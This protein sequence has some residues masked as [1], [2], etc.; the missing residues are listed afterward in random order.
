M[1]VPSHWFA[2]LRHFALAFF[3]VCVSAPTLAAKTY[4]DNGDGTVTDPTTG[5][6]WM[7]CAMGQT[8]SMFNGVG[9]CS[10]PAS[11]FE[12]SSSANSL[13]RTMIFADRYDWRLPNIRELLS[14]VDL[15]VAM[16]ATDRL[17][18]PNMFD[19]G[20]YIIIPTYLSSSGHVNFEDGNTS[21]YSSPFRVRLV[22]GAQSVFFI[23]NAPPITDYK[24]NTDGTV[25]N[26]TTG[27]TW[28]RCP[29]GQKLFSDTCSGVALELTFY[30]A[31]T[32]LKNAYTM[33][34]CLKNDYAPCLKANIKNTSE[35]QELLSLVASNTDWRFPT[36]DELLSN[37]DYSKS[38][39]SINSKV[40]P[41]SS[42]PN[43]WSGTRYIDGNDLWV[44]SFCVGTSYRN[45]GAIKKN[46]IILVRGISTA[47]TSPTTVT[48]TISTTTTGLVTTT[49]Q[50][51]ATKTYTD[52]GGAYVT[53]PTTGLVWMRC[54]MGQIW[55]GVTCTGTAKTYTFPQAMAIEQGG[56]RLPNVRELLSIVDR[57][58]SNP[59][60]DSIVFPN[61]SHDRFLSLSFTAGSFLAWT[62]NFNNG[63]ASYNSQYSGNPY[64][65][66]AFPVRLVFGSSP[67]LKMTHPDNDYI[68]NKDG[69]V[70]D[71]ITGLMWQ[72][73]SIGS[74]TL[75]QAKKLIS[76]LGGYTDWRLPTVDELI[77]LLDYNVLDPTMKNKGP[78]INNRIFLDTS[79]SPFLSDSVY[80][81][82]PYGV[83]Y[84]D[85][86]TGSVGISS[87]DNASVVRLVRAGKSFI[88]FTLTVVKSGT[89]F[90]GSSAVGGILCGTVCTGS[91][92]PGT[93]I[94]LRAAPAANVTWGGACTG[95]MP[96]CT[97]NMDTA[98]SVTATFKDT[99]LV[100]GLPSD[101]TFSTQTIGS[102]SQAQTVA[103]KNTG[104]TALNITSIT[105]SGDFVV[106]NNCG[107]GIGAG[108]FC[109]LYVSYKPTV[110]GKQTGILTITDDAL[111]S[112]HTISLTGTG[113]GAVA[114]LALN[115][116]GTV[117]DPTTGLIWMRC[118]MGQ[119]WDGTT[120]T[121]TANTYRFGMANALKVT[122]AGQGDWRVPNI[123]ELQT[124]VDRSVVNP[125]INRAAF[126]NTSASGF[127]SASAYAGSSDGAW[128]VNFYDGGADYSDKS[129]A[130]QVRL[131]RA[132]QSF[133]LLNVSRPNSD[134]VDH[135]DGTVTHT[136]TGLMWQKCAMGQ[137]WR[138]DTCTGTA[139]TYKWD[140]ARLLT[141]NLAGQ[142]DWRL[143]TE[144][145][146][147]SLSDYSTT[148]PTINT[149]LFPDPNASYFWSASA[150]AGNSNYA[151]YVNFNDGYADNYGG[152]KSNAFQVRLVRAGQ[153]FDPFSLNIS[154]NGTGTVSSAFAGINCGTACSGSYTQGTQIIL[155]ATPAANFISWD[156]AC[157]GSATT[158]TVTMDAAKSVT[159]TFSGAPTTTT[160][161][162]PTTTTTAIPTTTTT[163]T[164]PP[165]TTTTLKPTTTTTTAIPTTTT[166]ALPTTTTTLRPTTTTSV[167]TTTTSSTVTTTTT[168]S[169][170]ITT[171]TTAIPTTTTTALPTTTTTLR[172]TTTTTTAIPTTTTTAP[173]TTT[174]SSTV[175]TT[176]TTTLAN[177][178]YTIT[179]S[180]GWNLLGNGT[181]QPLTMTTLVG[182]KASS[183]TTVWKW[184]VAQTGWQFYAPSMD[185]TA[186][187]TYATN[188]NYL[189]LSQVNSG[190]GFWVNAAKAFS[191]TLPGGTAI[192]GN[193]FQGG[194]PRAL[195]KGWNLV[196]VGNALTPSA[197]N[198]ALSAS[199][200]TADVVPINLTTLW[201]WDNQQAKWYFYAP[202]LE[203]QGGTA[204]KDY[205]D[206]KG[207]L[208]F[209]ATNKL[210]G[211]DLGFWVNYP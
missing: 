55:N 120:C 133:N 94:I 82:Y 102:T 183:V 1:K 177:T 22:S 27:L 197:F 39:P 14:I 7:R 71:T 176:T 134:Y 91:Y 169:L 85:F 29:V 184:D 43:V 90:V 67:L 110:I 100:S 26:K 75:S 70:T 9:T 205:I 10:G 160:T 135:A 201:A 181:D 167:P 139:N 16:P 45:F 130:F 136:P 207:Y 54:V 159:A 198:M 173:P 69:T 147:L 172:P 170:P 88:P 166:T 154:K 151:W 109:S 86:L 87:V 153:S 81:S 204:L 24:F 188:K 157:T 186:L 131:V 195:K 155:I 17:A 3:L 53:D 119:V 23:D 99:A 95:N 76:N 48:S 46:K 107:T 2:L 44:S 140:A 152:A 142:T 32:A 141:N 36:I 59:A 178:V 63:D 84:V 200:P 103:L 18:F 129:N 25:T 21:N 78:T 165:T 68:D 122:F 12:S 89:G 182:D 116:D 210:L 6:V 145:E 96:T 211:S 4:T 62:I 187:Q 52:S 143:P 138:V 149:S 203:A 92:T 132:G 144:D 121:G 28:Q 202:N 148:N 79:N 93:A 123:R 34:N 105:T 13:I 61:T 47:A 162:A 74:Y 108:S 164:A 112:P 146:L 60:I 77:S 191:V 38:S 101:L 190:E 115:G 57:S 58:V 8:W 33:Q 158:C 111:G 35:L 127:W 42:C 194:K 124:M 31:E 175:T 161:V 49:T 113:L 114:P 37:I 208:D 64:D 168:T 125:A 118:S 20:D 180:T 72:R 65:R 5:L 56:M 179:L 41:F 40:F 206:R 66:S 174:T 171:T 196:A 104:S 156:G 80:A 106:T 51:P 185:A 192:S 128:G 15:S 98:K 150:Y 163:T 97:V 30:E 73:S 137:I 11:T 50:K 83:W 189:V 19:R 126:P 199:P 193:D 209:T 117:T